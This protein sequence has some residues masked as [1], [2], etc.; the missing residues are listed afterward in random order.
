[1]KHPGEIRLTLYA[2]GELGWWE[3]FALTRH[4]HRCP[5]CRRRVEMYRND[6]KVISE[7]LTGSDEFADWERLAAEMTANI[8]L[9][10]A[11]GECVEQ[12]RAERTRPR[13]QRAII[14]APIVLPVLV[15]AVV[16]LRMGQNPTATGKMD[17]VE[18]T[19]IETTGGSIEWRQGT[20]GL[21]LQIPPGGAVTYLVN[22]RGEVRARYVDEETG[23]VTIH[24]VYAQ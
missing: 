5:A 16:L 21:S 4:L 20:A 2:G 17:W 3:Q 18:G 14:L 19:L 8:H 13:W 10:L 22:A 11:A 23:Q 12:A 15:L 6:R 1:M 7:A 9:G 24:N